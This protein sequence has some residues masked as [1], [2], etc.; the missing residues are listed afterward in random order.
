MSRSAGLEIID[1]FAT[2]LI[3]LFPSFSAGV[4]TRRSIV[5]EPAGEVI[6]SGRPS[7]RRASG[8]FLSNPPRARA[9]DVKFPGL[10]QVRRLALHGHYTGWKPMLR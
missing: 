3:L 2:S 6:R 1:R 9:A 4:F 10:P 7:A 5:Q 8:C